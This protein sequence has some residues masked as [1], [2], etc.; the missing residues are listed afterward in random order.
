MTAQKITEPSEPAPIAAQEHSEP[1]HHHHHHHHHD[2]ACDHEHHPHAMP[3]TRN[4]I[5]VGRNDPCS[6]GSG[7]KHKKCCL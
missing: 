5:K 3:I 4:A 7:K 2:G 1:G 6:C